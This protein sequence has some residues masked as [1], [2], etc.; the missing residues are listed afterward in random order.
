MGQS[1]TDLW[2]N[3]GSVLVKDAAIERNALLLE[4]CGEESGTG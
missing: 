4:Q 3:V 1:A 2:N